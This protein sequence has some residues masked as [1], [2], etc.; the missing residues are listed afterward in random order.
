[1]KRSVIAAS[2]AAVIA[3]LAASSA[4]QAAL[5][6]FTVTAVDG[7]PSY[8]GTTLDQSTAVDVDTSIL[9]V[10]EVDPNDASGLT[11][12]VDTVSLSPTDIVYGAGTGPMTLTGASI[13]TKSWTGDNGD[14]FTETLNEV[15]SINRMTPNQIIVQLSGTV[16]DTG[17][18]FVDV[19]AFFVL[20]ATQ[21]GGVGT[22]TSVSFTDTTT[23]TGVIP[24]PSTWAMMALGFGAL[25]YAGFRRRGA[26]IGARF[27]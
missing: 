14:S 17:K 18:L 11:A 24:E 6:D 26:N 2:G 9:L 22:V 7:T 4:A 1:M 15:D 20:N 16:S 13:V 3:M 19:P 25:G 21:F 5:I 27:P 10:T 12:G 23:T 8:T